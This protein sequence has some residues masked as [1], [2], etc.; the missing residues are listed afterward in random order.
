ML[1]MKVIEDFKKSDVFS[2]LKEEYAMGS[3]FYAL[4]E[5]LAFIRSRPDAKHE[6]LKTIPQVANDLALSNSEENVE[7]GEVDIEGDDVEEDQAS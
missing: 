4:K 7:D 3:Y 5:A 1:G 6:D 2:E